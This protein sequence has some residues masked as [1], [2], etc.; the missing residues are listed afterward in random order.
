MF[1]LDLSG[2]INDL[3]DVLV[4]LLFLAIGLDED[5]ACGKRTRTIRATHVYKLLVSKAVA[6][7]CPD[8]IN[9]TKGLTAATYF[10]HR[11]NLYLIK[12]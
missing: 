12:T 3:P 8:S 9:H 4:S 1:K 5:I 6:R 2:H 10:C 7:L 11:L